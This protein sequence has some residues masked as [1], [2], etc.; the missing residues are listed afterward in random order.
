MVGVDQG[1]AGG[2]IIA[3]RALIA[4]G[5]SIAQ[6]ARLKLAQA[7]DALATARS[8]AR[9]IVARPCEICGREGSQALHV[10]LCLD[11]A[12]GA[13]VCPCGALCGAETCAIGVEGGVLLAATD[14]V[15]PHG[16]HAGDRHATHALAGSEGVGEAVPAH[17]SVLGCGILQAAVAYIR[18]ISIKRMGQATSTRPVGYSGVARAATGA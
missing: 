3:G 7:L 8:Q 17:P 5:P 18:L 10:R 6:I 14:A 11:E 13:I 4:A 2:L 15:V 1:V 9:T 16:V 12:V